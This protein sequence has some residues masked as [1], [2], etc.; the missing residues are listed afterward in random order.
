[1]SAPRLTVAV[2]RG[3]SYLAEHADAGGPDDLEID[4]RSPEGRGQWADVQRAIEWV[5]EKRKPKEQS[6]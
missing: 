3:L 1:V 4:D 6:T 2:L 5:R